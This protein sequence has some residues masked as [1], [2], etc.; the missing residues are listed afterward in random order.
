MPHTDHH[1]RFEPEDIKPRPVIYTGV[2]VVVFTIAVALLIHFVYGPLTR[3]RERDGAQT[4]A[5]AA[6][7]TQLPPQPNLQSTPQ[8]DFQSFRA[9][10]VGQLN[11]YNWI[12]KGKGVIGIP[13]QRAMDL[14]IQRGIP[15]QTGGR[16]F[17]YNPPQAGTRETGFEG[18]VEPE[19]R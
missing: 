5:A 11:K 8:E 12:D 4:P 3:E 16:G 6:R 2:G 17:T 15:P 14:T 19:P 18:K 1:V 7:S 10:Q 13:I 9:A